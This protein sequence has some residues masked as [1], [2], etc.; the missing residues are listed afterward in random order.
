VVVIVFV[1]VTVD[2]MVLDGVM[3]AVVVLVADG[4]PAVIVLV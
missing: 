3:V 2:V 4:R 1:G